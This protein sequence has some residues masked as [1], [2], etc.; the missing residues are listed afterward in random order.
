MFKN[1][2]RFDGGKKGKKHPLRSLLTILFGEFK[3]QCDSSAFHLFPC[4]EFLIS[5]CQFLFHY[6]STLLQLVSCWFLLIIFS[7]PASSQSTFVTF[8][9]FLPHI[10]SKPGRLRFCRLVCSSV[11]ACL[12]QRLFLSSIFRHVCFS[13]EL[14]SSSPWTKFLP[15][16]GWTVQRGHF[17]VWQQFTSTQMFQY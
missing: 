5:T 10:F 15:F 8:V 11:S 1:A 9:L 17:S 14:D 12:Y 13:S 2:V 16:K 7:V 6:I 4:I 3:N